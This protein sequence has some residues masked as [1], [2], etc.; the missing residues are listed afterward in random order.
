[1]CNVFVARKKMRAT[2]LFCHWASYCYCHSDYTRAKNAPK[3]VAAVYI[4][5]LWGLCVRSCRVCMYKATKIVYF[6][7]ENYIRSNAFKFYKM[8][9]KWKK[10]NSIFKRFFFRWKSDC[11]KEAVFIQNM[12]FCYYLFLVSKFEKKN[13]NIINASLREFI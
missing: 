5:N 8:L 4:L 6:F 13:C 11:L 10:L 12:R 1:M 2:I 3:L 7:S 9:F